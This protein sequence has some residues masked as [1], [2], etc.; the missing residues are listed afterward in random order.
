[1]T[2][3][4]ATV[5]RFLSPNPALVVA[6]AAIALGVNSGTPGLDTTKAWRDH[7]KEQVAKAKKAKRR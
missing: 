5:A 3:N 4:A 2:G 6:G 1:M 7:Q